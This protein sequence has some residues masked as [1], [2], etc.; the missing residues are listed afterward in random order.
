MASFFWQSGDG[1]RD[2]HEGMASMGIRTEVA[3]KAG[4]LGMPM[5]QGKGRRNRKYYNLNLFFSSLSL[6]AVPLSLEATMVTHKTQA[7]KRKAGGQ[8]L[9]L[10]PPGLG[11]V[12]PQHCT[13]PQAPFPRLQRAWY[14]LDLGN[15]ASAGLHLSL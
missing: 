4:A 7:Q 13:T 10:W 15:I 14:P 8:L 3:A 1:R 2:T 5:G 9:S 11:S 12:G 6:Q